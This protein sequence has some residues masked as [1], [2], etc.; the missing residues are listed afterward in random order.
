MLPDGR[1]RRQA[2]AAA[3]H[4]TDGV[5]AGKVFARVKPKLAIFSHGGTADT[6]PLVRQNY[7][8]PVEVGEDMM[9]IDIG[10]KID[11]HRFTPNGK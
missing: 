3:A 5:E 9:T 11:V 2:Q 4:H 10:E 6:I 8:G 1:T 7:S